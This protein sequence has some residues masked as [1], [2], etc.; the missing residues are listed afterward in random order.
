MGK[1]A[2]KDKKA[3]PWQHCETRKD[4]KK[5]LEGPNSSIKGKSVPVVYQYNKRYE[6][7]G[8]KKFENY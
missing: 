3:Q 4:L 7:W 6:E 5:Q 8:L 2:V 1:E